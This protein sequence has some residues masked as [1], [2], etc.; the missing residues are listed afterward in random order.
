MI[1]IQ[2]F[3]FGGNRCAGGQSQQNVERVKK[4]SKTSHLI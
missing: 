4:M 3:T 2:G 1:L